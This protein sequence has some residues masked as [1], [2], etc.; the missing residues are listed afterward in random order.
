MAQYA[1]FDSTKPP[2]QKIITIYDTDFAAYKMPNASDL[3]ELTDAQFAQWIAAPG[4][5]ANNNGTLVPYTP[6]PPSLPQAQAAQIAL[7]NAGAQSDLAAIVAPYPP[8]EVSTWEQQYREAMAYTASSTA[9]TP[10]LTAIAKASGETVAALASGV[11][12]KAAA[13]QAASGAVI[14]KRLALT[15]QINAAT[16]NAAVQAIVW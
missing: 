3:L 2:P 5:L 13:Y 16:T 4:Q 12:A 10:M 11:L 14:G 7:I 8:H 9:A 1:Y 15:A 6:P